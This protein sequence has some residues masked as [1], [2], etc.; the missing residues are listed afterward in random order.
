MDW[1]LTS[2]VDD[3][4]EKEADSP[5]FTQRTNKGLDMGLPSLTKAQGTLSRD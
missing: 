4:R 3:K 2:R 1:D 5:W